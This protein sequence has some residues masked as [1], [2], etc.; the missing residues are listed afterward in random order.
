MAAVC[1]DVGPNDQPVL[2]AYSVGLPLCLMLMTIGCLLCMTV[3]GL[4]AGLV[5][6]AA[7][8]KVLTISS[9]RRTVVYVRR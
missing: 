7:G 2:R 3:V 1:D 4:P 9:P 5:C 8:F 6:L